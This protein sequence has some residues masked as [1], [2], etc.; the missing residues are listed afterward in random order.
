M[1]MFKTWISQGQ[2]PVVPCPLRSNMLKVGKTLQAL[3]ILNSKTLR[4][5]R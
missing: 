4:E 2:P 3:W 1:I 5:K